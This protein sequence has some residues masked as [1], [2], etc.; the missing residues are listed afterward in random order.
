MRQAECDQVVKNLLGL[1]GELQLKPEDVQ[2]GNL[3]IQ[4]I[5]DRDQAGNQTSF[6]H[7]LV[8]RTVTLRQSDTNHFDELLARLVA[9]MDIEVGFSLQSSEYQAMRAKTRLDAVKAAQQKAA[10]MTELLDA[11]LG[12]VLRIGEPQ[13][14]HG[15]LFN[16]ANNYI[17]AVRTAEADQTSGTFSPGEIEIRV[18]IEVTFE[19]E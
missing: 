18:S 9:N 5:Y 10:A 15:S 8:D 11:K 7:F 3:S 19:I 17:S 16:T 14:S 6:R 12:R 13:E 1:R 2:T 4:K